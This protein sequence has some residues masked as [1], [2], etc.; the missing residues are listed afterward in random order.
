ML[1]AQQGELDQQ[2][3]L[4]KYLA[5]LDGPVQLVQPEELVQQEQLQK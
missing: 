3:Q 2:E 5:Q 4:Q 1:L